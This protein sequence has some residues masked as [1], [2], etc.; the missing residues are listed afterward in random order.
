MLAPLQ[1][2][3]ANQVHHHYRSE[4]LLDIL[5]SLAFSS[6]YAEIQQFEGNCALVNASTYLLGD[7]NGGHVLMAVDNVDVN[8]RTL[9]GKNTWEV[10]LLSRHT[11]LFLDLFLEKMS[12]HIIKISIN[13]VESNLQ[14]SQCRYMMKQNG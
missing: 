9:D 13:L 14:S 2:E 10:F 1:L 5:H 6:S 11:E 7:L 4:F 8:T 3:L 12:N